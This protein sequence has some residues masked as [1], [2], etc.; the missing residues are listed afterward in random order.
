MQSGIKLVRAEVSDT[1]II[2]FI[3]ALPYG[4][5]KQ[6]INSLLQKA[7]DSVAKGTITRGALLDGNFRISNCS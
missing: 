2:A 4:Q 7:V 5:I 3:E 6:I 1:D